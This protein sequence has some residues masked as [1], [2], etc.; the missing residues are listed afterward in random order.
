MTNLA[1][2]PV[3]GNTLAVT[4]GE[5]DEEDEERDDS[6][7]EN[8]DEGEGEEEEEAWNDILDLALP[9][10]LLISTI[11]GGFEL[12]S[13]QPYKPLSF[14][15]SSSLLLLGCG[16]LLVTYALPP[17]LPQPFSV[18]GEEGEEGREEG[19]VMRKRAQA[20]YGMDVGKNI[21]I[22]ANEAEEAE[23]GREG[24][25]EGGRAGRRE[26][27]LVVDWVNGAFSCFL[28]SLRTLS[29]SLKPVILSARASSFWRVTHEYKADFK[30]LVIIVH[31]SDCLEYKRTT[32]KMLKKK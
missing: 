18:P 30:L 22:M 8:V 21:Q 11:K 19:L 12:L 17:F 23:E 26:L 29:V 1:W 16:R 24:A 4:M 9:N 20:G 32:H 25:R 3:K 10:R 13:I 27:C 31:L 14:S 15:R 7:A 5:Q 2:S 6:E 28:S